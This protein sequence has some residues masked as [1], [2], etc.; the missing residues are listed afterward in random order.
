MT[1]DPSPPAIASPPG[2]KSGFVAIVGR[3][4]V[5]KSTLLNE[6]LGQKVA[7]V[8]PKPQ[9]T[10]SRILGIKTLDEAQLIFV[11]TP[12]LHRART[13]LN[14]RM[15]EVA[16]RALQE[17][18]E[19]LWL[20]D[21]TEG[22]R[23]ED[24]SIAGRLIEAGR[25]LCIVLNK[26]DRVGR[27]HL[28]PI[29]AEIDRLLPGRDVVP[30]S[31]RTGANLPELLGQI[32]RMLPEGPRYYEADTLTD[33]TERMLVQEVVREQVLLQTRDEVPYAVAVTIDRFEDKG[34]LAVV[35]ATIHVERASQKGIVIG[36]RGARIKAIGSAARLELERLLGR[37][38]HL[39]LFVRVQEQWTT[40]EALLKEFG[41]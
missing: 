16:E 9:T 14:R 39:E 33:Q 27:D 17:A 1:A 22:V 32:V 30:V 35:S 34:K 23:G 6:I 40:R 19:V 3:P 37:R 36:A 2:H 25:P 15:V 8:T 18:D 7:I 5:G 21:A 31:A 26:I 28:L 41:L 10:R 11:D 20:L 24:R 12:G 38:L 4:N 13:L 29:L